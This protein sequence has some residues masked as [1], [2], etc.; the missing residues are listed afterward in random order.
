MLYIFETKLLI[1]LKNRKTMKKLMILAIATVFSFALYSNES[2]HAGNTPSKACTESCSHC[3]SVSPAPAE[4]PAPA[5]TESSVSADPSSQNR[6]GYKTCHMCH[7][8]GVC[9]TCN[10]K[11]WFYNPYGTGKVACPNCT[12]G[13][14]STCG[15]SGKVYGILR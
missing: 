2:V 12:N 7:G 10:G 4:T 14:C 11:G 1:T 9:N 3:Q 15:G 8:S 6:Y 5:T 13:K